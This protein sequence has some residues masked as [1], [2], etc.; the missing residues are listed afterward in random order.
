MPTPLETWHCLVDYVE[1][2]VRLPRDLCREI[3]HYAKVDISGQDCGR[4]LFN[5]HYNVL[6]SMMID[7]ILSSSESDWI[8][9]WEIQEIKDIDSGDHDLWRSGDAYQIQDARNHG[10]TLISRYSY[11]SGEWVM[12]IIRHAEL[13]QDQPLSG[14]GSGVRC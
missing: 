4:I 11:L 2:C 1:Y 7:K 12:W 9:L 5:Q 8:R 10:D 13:D 6:E 3:G 14:R